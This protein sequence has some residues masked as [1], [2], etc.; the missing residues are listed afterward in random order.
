M[1]DSVCLFQVS[2][3]A[4]LKENQIKSENQNP[5]RTSYLK[6]L[7]LID[8]NWLL[9]QSVYYIYISNF[10]M[11]FNNFAT[12]NNF[13]TTV[14]GR[15]KDQK[16]RKCDKIFGISRCLYQTIFQIWWVS[17]YFFYSIQ[18]QLKII[19]HPS[20]FNLQIFKRT[21]TEITKNWKNFIGI[22]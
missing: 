3:C 9:W 6:F 7:F 4:L 18:N 2:D 12:K 13:S 16:W 8:L 5:F 15:K 22:E 11:E 14:R 1:E 10:Q 19:D 20:W 21:L 17:T